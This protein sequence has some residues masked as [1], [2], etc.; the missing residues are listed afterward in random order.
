MALLNC[1]RCG[2]LVGQGRL[3][4]EVCSACFVLQERDFRLCKD[5]LS[6]YPAATI[7]EL[8]ENTGI[9]FSRL[10]N[11]ITEGRICS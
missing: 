11:W 9:P 3:E 10:M 8:C 2:K 4:Q 7:R 5:Y 1:T 6:K